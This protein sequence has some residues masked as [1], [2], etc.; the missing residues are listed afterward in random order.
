MGPDILKQ[1]I[2]VMNTEISPISDVRGTA[3]YKKL[4]A[5]Q[6]VKAHFIK[7]FPKQIKFAEIA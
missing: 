6:L 2:E 4:L 7:L 3:E 1:T 5:N